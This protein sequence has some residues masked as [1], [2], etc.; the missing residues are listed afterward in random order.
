MTKTNS[1]MNVETRGSE[2]IIERI[3]DAPP[4][5]MFE[6]W[7]SCEHL[8][9]W[10]GPKEWPMHEC[11]MDFREGG[12]WLYCLR[13]P[14]EGDTAWGKALYD[15]IQKPQKIVYRD[16]FTDSNGIIDKNMPGS[17]T[18]L[19]FN[20]HNGITRQVST[21]T[22]DSP[23]SLQKVLDMGMIEGMN[24]SMERLDEYLARLTS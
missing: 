21:T 4:N 19:E 7:S 17:K 23:E 3:F 15:E 6:V 12:S 22:Y 8:K 13:G 18:V 9:H 5:L 11:E 24:S 2:L 10:W 16:Y 1:K 20:E 14:N